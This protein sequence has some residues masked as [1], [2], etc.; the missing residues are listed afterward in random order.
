MIATGRM[1]F[2]N[3]E[4]FTG[5]IGVKEGLVEEELVGEGFVG[6][7][8]VSVLGEGVGVEGAG[9]TGSCVVTFKAG[10]LVDI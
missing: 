2:L 8:I 1:R 10:T 3:A 5:P 4:L 7:G 9:E 6:E